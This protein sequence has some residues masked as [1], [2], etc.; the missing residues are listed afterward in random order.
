MTYPFFVTPH[1]DAGV[2]TPLL[3]ATERSIL[4]TM[5]RRPGHTLSATELTADLPIPTPPPRK[6]HDHIDAIRAVVGD[7]HVVTVPRRGWRYLTP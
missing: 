2:D 5:V 1:P 7:D 3:G 4:S 6:M